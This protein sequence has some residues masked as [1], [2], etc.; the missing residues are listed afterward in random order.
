MTG[1]MS[2]DETKHKAEGEALKIGDEPTPKIRRKIVNLNAFV[3]TKEEKKRK[4]ALCKAPKQFRCQQRAQQQ[5]KEKETREMGVILEHTCT[6]HTGLH[7][8]LLKN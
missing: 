4:R 2:D 3:Y 7:T 6:H 5:R 1:A 8:G